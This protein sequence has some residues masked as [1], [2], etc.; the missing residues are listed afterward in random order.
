MLSRVAAVKAPRTHNSHR[1]TGCSGRRR[2]G[3]ESEPQRPN[4]SRHLFLSAMLLLLVMMC[5]NAGGAAAA[6]EASQG[7]SS[8]KYYVWRDVEGGEE[9]VSSLRV[10]SLVEMNGDVLAV[11]EAH[12]TK[13]G[14]GFTGIASELLALTE[15]Q[16]GKELDKTKLK[17]Q[18][19]GECPSDDKKVS[20]R[21]ADQADSQKVKKVHVSR[22]TTVVWGSDIYMLAGNYSWTLT[23]NDQAAGWG[24]LLVKGNVSKKEGESKKRILWNDN[25]VI[26]WNYNGNQGSLKRLVGGGGS[27]VKMK[28]GTLVFPLEGTKK[29]N[30]TEKDGKTVSLII[31]SKD[32]KFW[33]L[34]KEMSAGGCSVPSVVEWEKDKKLMMMTACGDGRRRVYESGDKGES[35]TEALGTLSRVWGNKKGE[36]V[37]IFRSGFI[38]ATIEER[39][40]MLV[41]LPVYTKKKEKENGKG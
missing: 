32:T 37:E 28:D 25:Y 26:P 15:E 8:V 3:G 41:T 19:L 13:E 5:C 17:T 29:L 10:P 2:E 11:A 9:T 23:E 36:K 1:V 38:T 27:G 24:L 20:C 40:V 16:A 4:M 30:G 21:M 35:W 6:E 7:A 39:D 34:S 18:V 31:Y 22:P 33:T 12:C 14:E